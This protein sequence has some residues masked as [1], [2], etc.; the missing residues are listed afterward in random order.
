MCIERFGEKFNLYFAAVVFSL[1]LKNVDFWRK[2]GHKAISKYQKVSKYLKKIILKYQKVSIYYDHEYSRSSRSD[3]FYK[4]S[5]SQN[6][7]KIHKK[8]SVLT[9]LY[10]WKLYKKVT[11]AL[12]FSCKF[13]KN[14][15]VV[16]HLRTAAS[17]RR[18]FSRSVSKIS[19]D[20]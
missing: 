3:M 15:Y 20:F 8:V 19:K 13:F 5:C 17:D 18:F 7:R 12:L 4:K 16:E 9:S 2:T 1:L 10:C 6:F 14:I 11:P